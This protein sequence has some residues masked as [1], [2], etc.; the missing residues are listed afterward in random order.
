MALLTGCVQN[1]LDPQINNATIRLLTRLGCEVVVAAGSGCCGALTHHLGKNAQ[2]HELIKA[3]IEA[4]TREIDG[5]GLDAIVV[6]AS[7]CGTMIKDYGFIL[8]H[9]PVWA[10]RATVISDRARDVSEMLVDLDLGA[11]VS[12]D[13]GLTP[14]KVAYHAACSLQHGQGVIEQPPSLLRQAGFE[15]SAIAEGHLCCGSAGTYNLLQPEPSACLARSQGGAHRSGGTGRGRRRKYRL[16]HPTGRRDDRAGGAQ[17]RTAG[18]GDRGPAP[19]SNES[20]RVGV[21]R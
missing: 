21:S 14:I 13:T 4:W 12:L 10:D 2:A 15:V 1:V 3:N 9:D 11:A 6:N 17:C 5:A 8:R 16:H 18:L 20:N 7:G 19:K